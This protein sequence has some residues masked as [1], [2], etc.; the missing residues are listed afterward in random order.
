MLEVYSFFDKI[1]IY[2]E[3]VK[4][5]AKAISVPFWEA[6]LSPLEGLISVRSCTY[7]LKLKIKVPYIC[8]H[9]MLTTGITPIIF[10]AGVIE[11]IQ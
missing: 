11:E 3:H 10:W 6:C 2:F 1:I 9:C 4:W 7:W 8:P 5:H